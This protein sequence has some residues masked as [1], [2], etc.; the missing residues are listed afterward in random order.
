[1]A[2]AD[3]ERVRELGKRIREERQALQHLEEAHLESWLM[4]REAGH[5]LQEIADAAGVSRQAVS[6]RLGGTHV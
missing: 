2:E 5:T 4:A 1:M 3:L 6:Q